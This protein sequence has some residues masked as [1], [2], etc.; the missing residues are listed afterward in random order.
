MLGLHYKSWV[1]TM[2][3]ARKSTTN[4]NKNCQKKIMQTG[5]EKENGL[6]VHMLGV[7]VGDCYFQRKN[8]W[9]SGWNKG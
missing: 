6:S 1:R 8:P 4:E 5:T 7:K 9:G 2:T 3:E